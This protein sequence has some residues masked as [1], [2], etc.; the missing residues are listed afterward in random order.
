[1]GWWTF[2]LFFF[3]LGSVFKYSILSSSDYLKTLTRPQFICFF[4]NVP[5]SDWLVKRLNVVGQLG[6]W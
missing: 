5:V 3:F 4:S 2:L 1:M 6:T